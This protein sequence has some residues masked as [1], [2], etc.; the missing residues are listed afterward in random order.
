MGGPSNFGPGSGNPTNFTPGGNNPTPG[1][2]V[3]PTPTTTPTSSPI[4]PFVMAGATGAGT[5]SDPG[6]SL[7]AA[8]ANTTSG[9]V[10][11]V[12][13]SPDPVYVTGSLMIPDGVSIVGRPEVGTGNLPH[14]AG[15][16]RMGS[17]T[18]LESFRSSRTLTSGFYNIEVT[19]RNA[20][21][22][23]MVTAGRM[24]LE[25]PS[26]VIRITDST[27]VTNNF[28]NF[29][30]VEAELIIDNC[31]LQTSTW[32]ITATG[33]STEFNLNFTDNTSNSTLSTAYR[34]GAHG[35]V[36]V[37]ENTFNYPSRT[38]VTHRDGSSGNVTFN[39]NEFLSNVSSLGGGGLNFRSHPGG[40]GEGTI[41]VRDNV[42]TDCNGELFRANIEGGNY[43][44]LALDNTSTYTSGNDRFTD[45]RFDITNSSRVR[46]RCEG[47]VLDYG[48]FTILGRDC[49]VDAGIQDNRVGLRANLGGV[50]R[51]I[52]GFYTMAVGFTG[53]LS[54]IVQGNT[55]GTSTV[56]GQIT[57]ERGT[58]TVGVE[59]M[60]SLDSD[61]NLNGGSSVVSAGVTPAAD[62]STN[63]PPIP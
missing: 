61:N 32:S 18:R 39:S 8:I 23:N 22:T 43:D 26:G 21:L 51:R 63:L 62:G 59:R 35:D 33:A 24:N 20:T 34:E 53:Q 3:N 57:V 9:D 36:Q 4:G 27:L 37:N 11:T 42:A 54:A 52:I 15:T 38:D 13:Y 58:A 41:L 1:P 46:I 44:I 6:G 49:V 10:I 60:A 30:G 55:C 40:G 2:T 45:L 28:A 14:V 47:N 17:D 31:D 12:L 7:A 16:L 29:A 56:S 48:I 5:E 19:G 25:N 50:G